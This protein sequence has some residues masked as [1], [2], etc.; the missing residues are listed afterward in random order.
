MGLAECPRV[1]LRSVERLL[2]LGDADQA[3][4]DELLQG[5]L[6]CGAETRAMVAT[7]ATLV[8]QDGSWA[9]ISETGCEECLLAKAMLN[10][11]RGFGC[12]TWAA[13]V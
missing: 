3:V 13:E 9:H 1:G 7:S 10:P 8:D 6:R 4:I 2:V 12:P 11:P 5:A